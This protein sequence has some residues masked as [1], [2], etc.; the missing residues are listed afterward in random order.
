M[1]TTTSLSRRLFGS[2][3][4]AALVPGSPSAQRIPIALQLFSVREQCAADL[5]GT[6]REVAKLGYEGVEFAGYHGRTAQQ[7]RQLL[8]ETHLTCC[9]A[10]LPIDDL[11]PAKFMATVEFH[12]TLGNRYLVVPGLPDSYRQSQDAWR[13]TAQ[14]FSEL[15]EK[16]KPHGMRIG[17]HNHAAEFQTLEGSR[18]WDTF[19]GQTATDVIMQFDIGNAGY[20][21]ADPVA[22]L[23]RYPG[24]ARTVHVKDYSAKLAD[25]LVGDGVV[26]WPALFRACEQVAGTEWYVVEHDTRPESGLMEIAETRRRLRERGR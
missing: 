11:L 24:R 22:E 8:D 1:V 13:K 7:L 9:G 5:P 19:F 18:P 21:G 25:L 17:Y 12:R 2:L 3:L 4:G 10:H 23:Q 16:L 20:E 6:L 26:N 14:L 15:S